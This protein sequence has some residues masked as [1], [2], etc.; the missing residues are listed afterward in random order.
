MLLLLLLFFF[1]TARYRIQGVREDSL[2]R[3][4]HSVTPIKETKTKKHLCDL[5]QLLMV[6]LNLSKK[7]RENQMCLF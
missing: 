4:R 1:V 6:Q 2:I 7:L 3:F 5:N